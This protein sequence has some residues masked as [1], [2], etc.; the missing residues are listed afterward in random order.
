MADR[1]IDEAIVE[2]VVMSSLA[3]TSQGEAREGL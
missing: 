1:Y 3:S 2:V